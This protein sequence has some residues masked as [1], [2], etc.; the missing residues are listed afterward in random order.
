[1]LI[2]FGMI[3]LLLL[4]ISNNFGTIHPALNVNSGTGNLLQN[5]TYFLMFPSG[6]YNNTNYSRKR[7]KRLRSCDGE[8]G[9]GVPHD[10]PC[11]IYSSVTDNPLLVDRKFGLILHKYF[12]ISSTF[13]V[14][15]DVLK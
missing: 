8:A 13:A 2:L 14:I 12:E 10:Q 3:P 7:L 5:F 4:I 1:M 6:N 11:D 9:I 15:S